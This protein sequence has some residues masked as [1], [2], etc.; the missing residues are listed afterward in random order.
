MKNGLVTKRASK[1]LS[2]EEVGA[3]A[4]ADA[5]VSA[6]VEPAMAE[7][8]TTN[9]DRGSEE[10]SDEESNGQPANNQNPIQ[11][12]DVPVVLT[13][14][15]SNNTN[16][17]LLDMLCESITVG[18]QVETDQEPSV[19][20]ATMEEWKQRL[21]QRLVHYRNRNGVPDGFHE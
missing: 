11:E 18:E 19:L 16:L 20:L 15:G 6:V 4:A 13:N 17:F 21:G 7:S 9:E 1:R 10:T 5:V 2:M 3:D 8:V 14:Y 12:V